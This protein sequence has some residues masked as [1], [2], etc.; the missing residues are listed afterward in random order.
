M[1]YRKSLTLQ[2]TQSLFQ[3]KT[4]K[5]PQVT[6]FIL[7]TI[8]YIIWLI[9]FNEQ[10][11]YKTRYQKK[12]NRNIRP[13][14]YQCNIR[15]IKNHKTENNR[16]FY[17]VKWKSHTQMKPSWIEDYIIIQQAPDQL[18]EYNYKL[19]KKSNEN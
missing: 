17:L 10:K 12:I 9:I 13:I 14:S 2:T 6:N 8:N 15:K 19:A 18:N 3:T 4:Q 16:T 7:I 11:T 1:S 5:S